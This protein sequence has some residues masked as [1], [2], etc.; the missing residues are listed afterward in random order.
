[1]CRHSITLAQPPVFFIHFLNNA[2]FPFN[3]RYRNLLYSE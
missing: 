1:M 2:R 3:M